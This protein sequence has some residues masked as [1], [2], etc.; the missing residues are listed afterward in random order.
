MY[1]IV[2]M[3]YEM[4]QELVLEHLNG[5]NGEPSTLGCRM[6]FK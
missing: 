5:D 3:N 1:L 6:R 2:S 4:E